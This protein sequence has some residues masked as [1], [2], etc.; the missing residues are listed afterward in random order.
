MRVATTAADTKD[1]SS[2]EKL[3]ISEPLSNVDPD[4]ESK[5]EKKGERR[6][7]PKTPKNHKRRPKRRSK[8]DDFPRLILRR[9]Q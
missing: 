6:E 4:M 8:N 7:S 1:A 2:I 9:L 3:A 5:T